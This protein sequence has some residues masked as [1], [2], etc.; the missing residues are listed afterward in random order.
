MGI[1]VYQKLERFTLIRKYQEN[2]LTQLGLRTLLSLFRQLRNHG[3][4]YWH[5]CRVAG[6]A[7][8]LPHAIAYLICAGAAGGLCADLYCIRLRLSRKS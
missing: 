8:K 2:G 5:F 6:F 3:R 4:Q 7:K 1:H